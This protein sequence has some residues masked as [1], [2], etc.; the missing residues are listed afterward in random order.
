M[1]KTVETEHVASLGQLGPD[2]QR[3]A[4]G[5]GAALARLFQAG[6]PVP[7]GFV[8]LPAAFAG[9][10]LTSQGWAKVHEQLDRLRENGHNT[11]AVRSSALAEDS[12]Q[13]S[14]A[15]QF[16]SVLCVRTPEAIRHAIFTVRQSRRNGRAQAYSRAKGI[17]SAHEMA[18]VVQQMVPAQISGLLFTADPVTG[19]RKEMTGSFVHGFGDRLVSGE[20]TGDSFRLSR[21]RGTYAGPDE[22]KRHARQLHRLGGLLE[23][24]AGHPQDI[25]WA[26]ASGKLFLLQSRPITTL[27]PYRPTTGEWND[28]LAGDFLWSRVNFGEAVTGVMT[29]LTWTVIRLVLRD[30]RFLPQHHSS[31][32]IA[33]RPYLNLS[34]FASVFHALGKDTRALLETLEPT[35]Y[36]RLPDGMDIPLLG[37]SK[38]SVLRHL[39]GWIRMEIRQ[40]RAVQSLEQYLV[41]NPAWCRQARASIRR[42]TTGAELVSLWQRDILPHVVQGVWVVLGSVSEHAR[43]SAPLRRKLGGLVGLADADALLSDPADADAHLLASL[44]PLLGIA[45]VAQGEMD[46]EEYLE[47]FGHRGPQEFELS[48]ARPAE[49]SEWIDRQVETFRNSP[50]DVPALLRQRRTRFDAAWD[51]F[52]VRYPGKARSTRRRIEKAGSRAR[53]REAA[54]SEYVRDRWLA[55]DFALQAGQ[56]TGLGSDV[57][58]LTIDELLDALSSNDM[59]VDIAARKETHR[60]YRSL[61]PYPPVIRGRFD[62]LRWAADPDRRSDLFDSHASAPPPVSGEIDSPAVRGAAGSAGRAEGVVRRLDDPREGGQLRPGEILVTTQT[63]IEWTL[64]FPRASAIVTDVGAP[65]SHAAIV[66]REL[67]IPAVVGCGDATMRLHTGDRVAVDG[68]RGEVQI[69]ED[70][71]EHVPASRRHPNE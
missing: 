52:R 12:A 21:A 32:N 1:S 50:V 51:R 59:A 29:P 38:W 22:L 11:F 9:D 42:A 3:L 71:K 4:G 24:V 45:R 8:I 28:S 39:P 57:F 35:G 6:H 23:K 43:A 13:A 25:E 5:K 66:A 34:V 27:T 60:R 46:R 63:D 17:E 36:T 20:A 40:R 53:K 2:G 70:A 10:E 67:G 49:D 48:I 65:L 69:L 19:S 58:F 33:G 16:K 44:A 68:G 55:R 64:L 61:P 15:G 18:V 30:W 26:I 14:F 31:G 37:L 62:P 56:L 41:T 47:R 54:R 7:D